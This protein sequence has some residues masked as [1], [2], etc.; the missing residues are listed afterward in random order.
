MIKLRRHLVAEQPSG[1]AG[2]D[3]PR[4]NVF[5]VGPD[6]IAKGSLMG[7]FLGAS[8]NPDLINSPNL[9]AQAAVDAEDLAVNDC[10]QDQE[11]KDL[12]AR[13][14]DR[15]IPVFLL[16]FFVEAVHLGDLTGF[17]VAADEDDP[18][19]VSGRIR[20]HMAGQNGVLSRLTWP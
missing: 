2:T 13:L 19:R 6:E 5:G 9:R 17:V 7:N 3:C 15:G 14:P 20:Q 4:L 16:A 18:I 11:V 8:N 1:A 10:G 12:A